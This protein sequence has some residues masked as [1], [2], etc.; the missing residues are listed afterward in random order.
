MSL[1]VSVCVHG[2]PGSVNRDTI[3]E[4]SLKIDFSVPLRSPFKPFGVTN[5]QNNPRHYLTLV[6]WSCAYH[7]SVF[8][9]HFVP[10][11]L[12]TVKLDP[13]LLHYGEKQRMNSFNLEPL[14][15]VKWRAFLLTTLLRPNLQ[16][17][18]NHLHTNIQNTHTHTCRV[19][20]CT[21]LHAVHAASVGSWQGLPP[22]CWQCL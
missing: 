5:V 7:W 17:Q 14:H 9:L 11:F 2:R 12:Q 22:L 15:L 18:D 20:R 21:F 16:H 4:R 1:C 13:N 6:W 3:S 10:P 8:I 19:C